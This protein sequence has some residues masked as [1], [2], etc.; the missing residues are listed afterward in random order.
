M[1]LVVVSVKGLELLKFS[2]VKPKFVVADEPVAALDVS[3]QA[4]IINL[5]NE[6]KTEIFIN[7]FIYIP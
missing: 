2:A 4:Q 3:I 5:L 7:F 6:L 1:N